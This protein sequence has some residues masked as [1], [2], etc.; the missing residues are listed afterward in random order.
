MTRGPVGELEVEVRRSARRRR[1]VQAYRRDG[2]LVVMMPATFSAAQEAEWVAKMRAKLTARTTAG[3][4]GAE[5]LLDHA[6]QLSQ[7]Y[8]SGR[9]A[10]TSVRWVTNMTTR[11]GSCTPADGTI[12]LSHR[13]RELPGWVIDYVLVHELAHLLVPGHNAAFHALV[14][15]YPRAERAQGFLEGLSW[16]R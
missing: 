16:A 2:K 3:Q 6:H 13:L 4:Y 11:W 7:R 15:R 14:D 9:A 5:E 1:T 10:P 8:L 12:R